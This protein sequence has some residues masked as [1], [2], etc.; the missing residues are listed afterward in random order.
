MSDTRVLVLIGAGS[1]VFTRGLLADLITADDLGSWEIRLVDVNEE[2]L[3]VAERLAR[4]MVEAREAGNRITVRASADRRTELPDADYVVTCVGVGGRPAWQRDHEICQEHGVYQ[5]V[6]DSVMPG[7]ISRLLRT[8]PVMVDV[9]RDIA[10]LA[11]DAF[12]FNYSNPMT[13]NV[14]AMTRYA[15]ARPVGL[16][17]GMH[18][19]QRELAAFAGLPFEET[20]TLYAGINHL[21]FIYDF[22]HNGRDAWPGVRAR[23]ERELAEPADPADIGAIWENGK[24]WHNPFSWEIFR[25]YGAYPA[26]NDRHV[27]EFFPERWAGGDYYGKKLGV[28]AFSVPEILQWGEDRYQGMRAQADDDA[29]LDAASFENSTGEQEQLIAIIRSITFDRREMFSVNVPNRGSVPGLPDEAALEVPAVATARGL[30]PVSVPDLSAPLTAILARRLTSVELATEAAMKGDRGL[31]VEAMIA[32][33]AVTDPDAAVAL[34]D[35]LL[36][37]QRAFLPRFA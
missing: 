27:L 26:A 24:A 8:V 12:F 23:M 9:A 36:D 11:P 31:V 29:P 20:S 18:H 32:D 35:A 34:T 25:R 5:P 1:A 22:R 17:H 10:D 37:A 6:G 2:A 14:Q 19:V 15:G 21:T 3:A 33:G 13:A 30:R 4:R 7:G 16:C 28:D